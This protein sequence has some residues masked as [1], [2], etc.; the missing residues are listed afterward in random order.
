MTATRPDGISLWP[1]RRRAS[2]RND[3][4]AAPAQLLVLR[5]SR[6]GPRRRSAGRAARR[7]RAPAR[8]RLGAARA[9]VS[10]HA[11]A[12][13]IA[14]S[15]AA[16]RC[17]T[18]WS[19]WKDHGCE[20]LELQPLSLEETV[21]GRIA[22]RRRGGRADEAP[23]LGGEPR[24]ATRRSRARARGLERRLLAARQGVWRLGGRFR[25]GGRLLELIGARIGQLDRRRAVAARARRS[26]RAARLVAA[27]EPTRAAAAEELMRPGAD[28]RWA[29]R[30]PARASPRAPA[31][32]RVRSRARMSANTPGGAP[33]PACGR[34]RSGRAERSGDLLRFAV[35][36][37]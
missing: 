19:L 26:R 32:R 4:G 37:A 21:A 30:T 11:E 5:G 14:T 28:R 9:A 3:A 1:L 23:A 24:R 15:G 6:S 34:A 8:L 18:R 27:R 2:P 29:R 13:V 22:R 17:P 31:V 20:Y 7:R 33:E 16:S 10:R 25:A 35:Y 12:T 36:R